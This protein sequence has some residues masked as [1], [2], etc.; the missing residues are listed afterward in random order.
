MS[1]D[2]ER[3]PLPPYI[4]FKTFQGFI[5]KLHDTV[6]PPRVDSTLLKT[7][8]GSVGRQI[9]AALRFLNFIDGNNC[10]TDSLKTVV[11][12]YGNPEWA[13]TFAPEFAGAYAD[14]I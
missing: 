14:L 9:T 1:K 10:T 12:A 2:D 4:P 3:R 5:Q 6:I 11:K 13:E 7:Y 8:S